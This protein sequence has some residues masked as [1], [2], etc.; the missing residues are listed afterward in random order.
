MKQTQAPKVLHKTAQ[1][2]VVMRY[3]LTTTNKGCVYLADRE[4]AESWQAT[5]RKDGRRADLHA[6]VV[7]AR[8]GDTVAVRAYGR[9]R[10][11]LVEKIGRS[12]VTVRYVTNART[13]RTATKAVSPIELVYVPERVQT[14]DEARQVFRVEVEA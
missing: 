10:H 6:E 9:F 5:W 1:R 13:G 11:G 4:Q 2:V 7:T 8:V 3:V 12:L 14:L